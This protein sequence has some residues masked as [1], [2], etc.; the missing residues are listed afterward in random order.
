MPN[1]NQVTLCGHLTRNP[2]LSYLPSQ[3][4]VV[5][6]GIA[7][8]HIWK[9][10]DGQKRED[11]CFIDCQAFGKLAEAISKYSKKGNCLLIS[12]QLKFDQWKDKESK[13]HSKHRVYVTTFQF[14]NTSKKSD[15]EPTPEEAKAADPDN[16]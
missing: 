6:F 4:A 11:A 14:V 1:F 15:H 8:N 5:S 9:S 16:Y 3:T 7:V 10:D 2:E 13:S 12:G